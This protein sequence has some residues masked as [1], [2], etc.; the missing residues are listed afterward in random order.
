MTYVEALAVELAAVGIRGR[1]RRRIL[2]E[3]AAHLAEAP[4]AE[5]GEPK[6]LAAR[7]ADELGTQRAQR[8]VAVGFAALAVTGIFYAA[9]LQLTFDAHFR[10]GI[11]DG[12]NEAFGFVAGVA[13]LVLPQV[14]FAAGAAAVL[15][16]FRLRRAVA[17]PA[18][19]AVVL[20]RRTAVALAAATASLAALALFA[21]EFAG[22]LADWWTTTAYE[23]SAATTCVLGGAACACIRAARL[24]PVAAGA[25][26]GLDAD[27]GLRVAPWRLALIVAAA[28]GLAVTIM[29]GPVQGAGEAAAALAGYAALGRYL[30]LR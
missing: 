18:A 24:R 17:I 6:L 16:A 12:R 21:Y 13:V 2:A 8:A 22:R 30:A 26:G 4:E 27:L 29:N 11:T 3:A 1:L 10:A 15:R 19:E 9:T 7:F 20:L 25:A 23:G 14:A 28:T 5:F